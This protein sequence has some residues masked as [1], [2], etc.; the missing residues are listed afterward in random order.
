VTKETNLTL[1]A[2]NEKLIGILANSSSGN[3]ISEVKQPLVVSVGKNLVYNEEIQTEKTLLSAD[4]FLEEIYMLLSADNSNEAITAV[5]EQDQM[6]NYPKLVQDL[7]SIKFKSYIFES[8]RDLD[9][10]QLIS[11]L[12]NE[13]TK[14]V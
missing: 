13:I 5:L 9:V 10:K 8:D 11:M 7:K 12:K 2:Q 3:S 14:K 6:A 4:R 1:V